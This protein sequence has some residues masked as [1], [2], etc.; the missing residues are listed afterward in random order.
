MLG[1]KTSHVDE[2]GNALGN[3]YK[4]LNSH[5][6]ALEHYYSS[7]S[8]HEEYEPHNATYP[9]GNIAQV[10]FDNNNFE[11][12]LEYNKQALDYSL[13]IKNKKSRLSNLTYDYVVIGLINHKLNKTNEAKSSFEKAL[14]AGREYDSEGADLLS[15][16]ANAL[17][18]YNDIGDYQLCKKLILEGDKIPES[19]KKQNPNISTDFTIQKN[20]YLLSIGSMDQALLP[21]Q[22]TYNAVHEDDI[23]LYS[24]DY[25][26]RKNNIAKTVA[27]YNKLIDSTKSKIIKN[28][29]VTFSDIEE[30]YKNKKLTQQNQELSDEIKS[31]KKTTNLISTILLLISGFLILQLYNNRRYKKVN[32]LLEVRTKDLE[33]S[34][35]E[36]A[37]SNEE[38][39]RF[40]FH[41]SHDLKTPLRN[42]I[43]F[44]TLLE[45][46]LTEEHSPDIHKYISFIKDGGI[47]MNDLIESTLEYSTQSN[48]QKTRL[49]E[50]ID[51]NQLLVEIEKS[52]PSLIEKGKASLV[53]SN[54]LP[55]IKAHKSSIFLLFQNLIENGI[56]YNK[57]E[58]PVITI[59]SVST[60]KFLKINVKD[61]GIGIPEEHRSAVFT[62]FSRLHNQNEYAGSGLG[63]SICKKII[64]QLNGEIHIHG[65]EDEGCTFEIKVPLDL[66]I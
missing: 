8:W 4:R 45:K 28:R 30:K 53:K 62:M 48:F 43:N 17:S 37:T 64:D 26:K 19:T 1:N 24:I 3:F 16:I 15:A 20:K 2:F 22:L 38:L 25:Y 18:F 27:Y 13:K 39:E 63:L 9:L 47:R 21:E 40:S 50:E 36:L 5:T 57:S 44:S 58:K 32:N 59:S 60:D 41:A 61:N 29:N 23:Y 10:Y 52:N 65:N 46:K 49:E 12:A 42:I 34:N 66:V 51:L 11:K 35:E 56:K 7:L 14:D 31:R 33:K 55:K 54:D 6:L